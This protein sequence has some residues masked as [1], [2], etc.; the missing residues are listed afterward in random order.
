MLFFTRQ[1]VRALTGHYPVRQHLRIIARSWGRWRSPIL[2]ASSPVPHFHFLLSSSLFFFCCR[3]L[4]SVSCRRYPQAN[5]HA[6]LRHTPTAVVCESSG[7]RS[8]DGGH[9][10]KVRA[11][12]CRAVRCSCLQCFVH[13]PRSS[14]PLRPSRRRLPIQVCCFFSAAP[15]SPPPPKLPST[16]SSSSSL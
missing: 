4:R 13:L 1:G 9:C 5:G 16:L 2:H 11:A 6:R 8:H 12:R 14:R 3:P 15:R 7:G 10:G